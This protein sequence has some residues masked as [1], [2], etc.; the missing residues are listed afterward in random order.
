MVV[1]AYRL[2]PGAGLFM[3]GVVAVGLGRALVPD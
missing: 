1:G 2:H 3:V